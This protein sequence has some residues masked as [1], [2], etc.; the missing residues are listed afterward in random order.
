MPTA[1]SKWSGD[2]LRVQVMF[3]AGNN[4]EKA[5]RIFERMVKHR[6]SG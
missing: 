4:L 2:E 1:A 6:A 3:Y 5:R